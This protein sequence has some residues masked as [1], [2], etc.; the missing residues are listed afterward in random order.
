MQFAVLS[1]GSKGNAILVEGGGAR[2]LVDCG[3]HP[4]VLRERLQQVGRSLP[5]IDALVVT[6]G[7]ADHVA[8]ARILAGAF[9]LLTYATHRT[10]KFLGR[11]GGVSHLA[12]INAGE[13]FRIGSLDIAPFA[14]PHDA[15][16]S[17]GFV[18]TDGDAR[19]GVCTDLG[20]VTPTVTNALRDLDALYLE[21]NHDLDMLRNGPYPMP[22]KRRIASPLGHLSNDEARTL[23]DD[24]FHA[25]MKH[26]L[27]AHLSE[28]NNTPERALDAAR[29]VVDGSDAELVTAPQHHAMPF[30]DVQRR[31]SPLE[32]A[33]TERRARVISA[34]S[35]LAPARP[36][37]TKRESVAVSRQLSL[38][39]GQREESR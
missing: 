3:L 32:P 26:V 38:F 24:V 15:P 36:T 22:L 39:G 35:R 20:H 37:P 12:P 1:S 11:T 4:K 8:G 17:V 34:L 7:H 31:G 5:Q 10:H 6:H 19:F 25:R 21:F 2:I 14:T 23:L 27:L 28:V 29:T 33:H 30:V 13:S 18:F 9:R 16:G